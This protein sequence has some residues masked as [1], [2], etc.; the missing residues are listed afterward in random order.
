M[1]TVVYFLLS[2]S[3]P[4]VYIAYE[5]WFVIKLCRGSDIN[6]KNKTEITQ[7]SSMEAKLVSGSQLILQLFFIVSGY[8]STVFQTIAIVSSFLQIIRCS[9]QLDIDLKLA[10]QKK[11]ELPIW[12]LGYLVTLPQLSSVFPVL[13]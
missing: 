5:L 1:E 4:F 8:S 9:I 13:R 6:Q 10:L 7:L 12:M 11:V 2:V 3:F